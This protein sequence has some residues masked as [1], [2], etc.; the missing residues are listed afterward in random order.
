MDEYPVIDSGES[1]TFT[2][3]VRRI[4][5]LLSHFMHIPFPEQ[6]DDD[7]WC[8]KYRQF[9]WLKDNNFLPINTKKN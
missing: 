1:A 4:N 8:E 5:A 6:L 2:D 3:Q 9:E 7:T